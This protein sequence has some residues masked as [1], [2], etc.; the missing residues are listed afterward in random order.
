VS[1][2]VWSGIGKWPSCCHVSSSVSAAKVV[3]LASIEFDGSIVVVAWTPKLVIW[4]LA[5][6]AVLPAVSARSWKRARA[7]EL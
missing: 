2:A 1:E 5:G 4:R 3:W 7:C 6:R